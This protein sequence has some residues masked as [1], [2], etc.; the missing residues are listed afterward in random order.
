MKK[1]FFSVLIAIFLS[2]STSAQ[3]E[4]SLRTT[5]YY[6]DNIYNSSYKVSDFVNNLTLSS[7]YNIASESQNLQLYYIGGVNYY[8]QNLN[9]SSN[10]HKAG[11][12]ETLLFG[13]DENTLNAGVNYSFR[14][15]RDNFIL[16]NYNQL[17][18]Y[19]NYRHYLSEN[20]T[21]HGGYLF[22]K[23][24]F[25]SFESF[26]H[27]ENKIF[28]KYSN[29]FET[30][31][32]LMLGTE[33]DLKDYILKINQSSNRTTQLG[34]Y[35]QLAQS[36]GENTGISG[37][38]FYRKNLESSSRYIYSDEFV[39]YEEELFNDVYSNDGYE[40]GLTLTQLI[41]S[42]L[43][44]KFQTM[45]QTRNFSNLPAADEYGYELSQN[46]MD[47]QF[48]AGIGLQIN[49]YKLI[50]GASANINWNFI[51][52]ASNDAYY[53]FDNQILAI[54]LGWGL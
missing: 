42:R 2:A 40:V 31:T 45:Y 13:E 15:N 39:Y 3:I 51:N 41:S 47:K 38:A 32:T 4:L 44:A 35:L 7:A 54:G 6:D 36:L 52:N 17:S 28:L 37:Y 48:S 24:N 5:N 20:S 8:Q 1:S 19:A 53:K 46:R 12:V 18:V 34:L 21:I 33:L 29:T 23:I 10:S 25:E 14:N 43:T 27:Y 26:S 11:I 16:F 49:L 30:K 22:N 9:K 50:P